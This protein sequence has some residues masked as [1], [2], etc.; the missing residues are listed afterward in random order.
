MAKSK[1]N[2]AIPELIKSILLSL[3]L[4]GGILLHAQIDSTLIVTDSLSVVE[5]AVQ[6]SLSS[7]SLITAMAD[8][9][10]ELV[11]PDSTMSDS[12]QTEILSFRT[13]HNSAFAVGEYLEFDI[14]YG[15]IKA[16]TATMAVLDTLTWEHRPVY[17]IRTT[18]SSNSF[19]SSLYKV[20][21]RVESLM[22]VDGLF[23]WKF[24]KHLREGRYKADRYEAF[25]QINQ[26]VIYQQKDTISAPLYVQDILA[27]FYFVRTQPLEIGKSIDIDNFADGKVYPLRVLVHRKEQIKV[28]AGKFDC[29]VVEPVLREEGLFK[30]TGKLTIWLT[31]DDRR[32]PVLMKSKILV[33]SID[34]RLKSYELP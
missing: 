2:S 11:V 13:V 34:V 21:D 27:S 31:D 15:V 17:L 5:P 12:A 26:R 1:S 23:S 25:D 8:S 33:G 18:A 9:L 30:Q 14:A 16:G 32:M 29:I 22:D 10:S 20:R 7:D 4:L 6:D 28:P 24:E 3:G 19:F